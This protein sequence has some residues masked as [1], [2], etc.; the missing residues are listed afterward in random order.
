MSFHDI[1]ILS[2]TPTHTTKHIIALSQVE[3]TCDFQAFGKELAYYKPTSEWHVTPLL[4][5]SQNVSFRKP[6]KAPR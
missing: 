2:Q 6:E 1:Y 4:L 5:F 3:H